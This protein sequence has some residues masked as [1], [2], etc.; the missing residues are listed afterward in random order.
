MA[1]WVEVMATKPGAEFE[2][3]NL[4][5]GGEN[6]FQQLFADFHTHSRCSTK[7]PTPPH[8]NNNNNNIDFRLRG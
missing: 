4:H 1:Q 6:Q 8:N 7:A 2:S 3:Q 5:G